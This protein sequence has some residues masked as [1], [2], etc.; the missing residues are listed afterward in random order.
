LV[1]FA[2]Y[3]DRDGRLETGEFLPR[4]GFAPVALTLD[5]KARKLKRLMFGS[6]QSQAEVLKH[7]PIVKEPFRPAPDYVFTEA[8]HPG[9]LHYERQPWGIDGRRWRANAAEALRELGL[10]A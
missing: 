2:S 7:F 1:E 9:T 8:P 5:E 3:H 4:D 10:R 6:H